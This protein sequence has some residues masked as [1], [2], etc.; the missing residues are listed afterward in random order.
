MTT[1]TGSSYDANGMITTKQLR[2]NAEK[3]VRDCSDIFSK[4]GSSPLSEETIQFTTDRVFHAIYPAVA[5]HVRH[6]D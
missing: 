1:A 3:L 2:A 4:S 5:N 6:N